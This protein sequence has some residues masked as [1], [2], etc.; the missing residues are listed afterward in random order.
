M[1]RLE[2]IEVANKNMST[3]KYPSTCF[4]MKAPVGL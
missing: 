4:M 1:K 2:T 3:Q